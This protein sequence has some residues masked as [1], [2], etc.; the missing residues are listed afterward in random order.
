MNFS[1][2]AEINADS[3]KYI[4]GLTVK[5]STS[6]YRSMF[7][8]NDEH[9]GKFTNIGFIDCFYKAINPQ[10]AV[11]QLFYSCSFTNCVIS[12]DTY[13]YSY[14]GT[15][16]VPA[17]T[18]ASSGSQSASFE[19]TSVYVHYQSENTYYI[20]GTSFDFFYP[21][22]TCNNSVFVIDN[23][24][25]N[26]PS[27]WSVSFIDTRTANSYNSFI[28]KNCTF[29]SSI[30]FGLRRGSYN[31]LAVINPSKLS[32]IS[33]L[34]NPINFV[35]AADSDTTC[36]LFATDSYN[37]IIGDPTDPDYSISSDYQKYYITINQLKDPNA[38]MTIGFLP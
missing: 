18:G 5:D 25:I 19:G 36:C 2:I 15:N 23:M 24:Y 30:P 31:Y 10:Q 17:I 21:S 1:N 37:T 38:L 6:T 4:R 34:I 3:Y 27:D 9:R 11:V 20:S 16:Y 14:S 7:Y 33:G 28:L 13:D 29:M 35:N 12:V 22:T 8:S 26:T 32:S